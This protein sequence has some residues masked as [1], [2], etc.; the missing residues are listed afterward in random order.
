MDKDL[1]QLD[2][3]RRNINNLSPILLDVL[4]NGLPGWRNGNDPIREYNTAIGI[5][6]RCEQRSQETGRHL[7]PVWTKINHNS[8]E[9]QR[10]ETEDYLTL[11]K[12]SKNINSLN[13]KT[14]DYLD[15]NLDGWRTMIN[16]LE[17]RAAKKLVQRLKNININ[18]A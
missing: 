3:W 18:T 17:I 7:L 14:V 5:V 12:W 13:N 11:F 1:R 16:Y 4:D 2:K 6:I 9:V 10:Q 8:G 15:K